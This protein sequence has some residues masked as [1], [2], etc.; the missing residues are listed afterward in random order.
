MATQLQQITDV[1][2][3]RT[4]PSK[5]EPVDPSTIKN[6][7]L[8]EVAFVCVAVTTKEGKHKMMLNLKAV[9]VIDDEIRKASVDVLV[10]NMKGN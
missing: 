8:V 2:S 1:N 10:T 7:D 9:T 4:A 3:E 6:G 5:Y